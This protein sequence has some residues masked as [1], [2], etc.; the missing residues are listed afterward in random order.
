MKNHILLA[1]AFE[2]WLI[3][4][5]YCQNILDGNISF[6]TKKMFV[7][8]LHNAIELFVKQIMLDNAIH[9]VRE[10][11]I[12][13]NL[14]KTD[15]PLIQEVISYIQ[16]TDLNDY[17][18]NL[19][20]PNGKKPYTID[21]SKLI[22]QLPNIIT[23]CL[24][25]SWSKT[26]R[27]NWIKDTLK[28]ALRILQEAR[29]DETHFYIDNSFLPAKEFYMLVGLMIEFDKIIDVHWFPFMDFI[30]L[31][32]WISKEELLKSFDS[33][34]Q[35]QSDYQTLIIKSK[36]NQIIAKHLAGEQS[37]DGKTNLYDK[38]LS[39]LMPYDEYI[40]RMC[41]MEQA[42]L[43]E[44]RDA[45]PYTYTDDDGLPQYYPEYDFQFDPRLLQ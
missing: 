22:D 34:Y 3:S 44:V 19:N 35:S 36:K 39:L 7:A 24:S 16:S 20:L 2:S 17:F 13:G 4:K 11:K 26:D 43:L 45:P 15:I 27:E 41:V 21:F 37:D 6:Q 18:K 40:S 30:F 8:T 38:T 9:S 23:F 1:N 25:E 14:N 33:H 31:E 5:K 10:L 29:N 32:P 12:S 28:P 42:K